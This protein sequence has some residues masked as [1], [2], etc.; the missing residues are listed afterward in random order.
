MAAETAVSIE[1]VRL[2]HLEQMNECRTARDRTNAREHLEDLGRMVGAYDVS[3]HLDLTV[4][5]EYD[6]ALEEQAHIVARMV[7]E[8][9]GDKALGLPGVVGVGV[10]G[11]RALEGTLAPHADAPADS[12]EGADNREDA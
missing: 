4:K 2:Q 1:Y 11:D 7:L 6:A 10:G 3:L 12:G 8:Q 9:M 5:H